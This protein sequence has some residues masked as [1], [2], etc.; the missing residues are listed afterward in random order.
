LPV[1]LVWRSIQQPASG[2]HPRRV[3]Q[4]H[5]IPIRLN[6]ARRGPARASSAVE[7]LKARRIHQQRFHYIRHS[8]PS[9][10]LKQARPNGPPGLPCPRFAPSSTG[11]QQP[12]IHALFSLPDL[13]VSSQT[14][15]P[16]RAILE[17]KVLFVRGLDRRKFL[18]LFRKRRH[19]ASD[20][21]AVCAS[22]LGFKAYHLSVDI[23]RAK[24]R[25]LGL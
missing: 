1:H 20:P 17:P 21:L 22:L 24:S 15:T 18:L 2:N 25:W 9:V 10:V 4:P 5:G 3:G 6:L 16:A 14:I 8:S 13:A 11:D 12:A 7:I 23:P 19:F